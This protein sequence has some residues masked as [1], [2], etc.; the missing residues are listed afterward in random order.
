MQVKAGKKKQGLSLDK[1]E[2]KWELSLEV[3]EK[4]ERRCQRE[5]KDLGE[6]GTDVKI[7][8]CA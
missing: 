1:K 3:K 6:H 5:G 2:G 8:F 7:L 4:Q